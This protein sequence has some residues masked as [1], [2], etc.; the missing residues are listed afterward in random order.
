MSEG[1]FFLSLSL[2]F[3]FLPTGWKGAVKA[4]VIAQPERKP[5]KRLTIITACHLSEM[6]SSV[7]RRYKRLQDEKGIPFVRIIAKSLTVSTCFYAFEQTDVR[8]RIPAKTKK[9]YEAPHIESIL[10]HGTTTV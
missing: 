2:F 7:E 3:F 8:L 10:N 4:S 1:F 9:H 6:K 5:G